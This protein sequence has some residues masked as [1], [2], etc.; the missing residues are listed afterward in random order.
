VISPIKVILT[1]HLVALTWIFFRANSFHIAWGYLRGILTW[2]P[3]SAIPPLNWLG[4][5]TLILLSVLCVIELAQYFSKEQAVLL[6]MNWAAQGMAYGTLL[7]LILVLG[8]VYAEIP[9]I[10]FSVLRRLSLSGVLRSV[11]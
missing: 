3:V 10:Y 7:I 4:G 6:R 5:R 11:L 9:F 1:F 2:Q 8:G